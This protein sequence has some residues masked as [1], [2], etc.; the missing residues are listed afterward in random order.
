[1]AIYEGLNYVEGLINNEILSVPPTTNTFNSTLVI[2]TSGKGKNNTL[3]KVNFGDMES[4]YGPGDD[5]GDFDTSVSHAVFA[6][7]ASTADTNKDMY[8]YKVGDAAK[9]KAVFYE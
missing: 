4:K 6:I 2:G 7:L 9:S 1:M 3:S 8:V 5:I